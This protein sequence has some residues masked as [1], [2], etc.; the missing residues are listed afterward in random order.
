[1]KYLIYTEG[2][3]INVQGKSYTVNA[4]TEKEAQELA[5]EQF[6]DEY[7]YNGEIYTSKG[8]KLNKFTGIS[9]VSM[10]MAILLSFINWKLDH[11]TVSIK[12]DL[13]SCIMAF[14]IYSAYVIRIKG[15]QRMNSY[16]DLVF[17]VL[18]ILLFSSF[19]QCILLNSTFTFIIWD[20]SIDCRMLLIIA[21]ILS[22]LG[23]KMLSAGCMAI[24]II[25][26]LVKICILNS[27]M[28]NLWGPMY[29]I[30]AGVGIITYLLIEPA[31]QEMMPY[32]QDCAQRTMMGLK[33]NISEAGKDARIIGKRMEN[34]GKKVVSVTKN[35][36]DE[37]TK[38]EDLSIKQNQNLQSAVKYDKENTLK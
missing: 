23:M 11:S 33:K 9:I 25:C 21:A 10:I 13:I 16:V 29:V 34:Y 19:I 36:Y 6:I 30:C 35:K 7:G 12:P 17:M 2:K 38:S 18:L 26:A 20:V 14:A 22:W 1:M 27:A 4:S 28:G 37:N 5:E 3:V 31:V 24:I 32:Y 15:L 8:K